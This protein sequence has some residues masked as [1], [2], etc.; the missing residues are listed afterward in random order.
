MATYDVVVVGAGASGCVVAAR[1]AASGRR[2][3]VV[4]AGPDLRRDVP[5]AVMLAERLSSNLA[6]DG[7]LG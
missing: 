4:E 1:L 3:C 5:A 2:V 7:H 6:H